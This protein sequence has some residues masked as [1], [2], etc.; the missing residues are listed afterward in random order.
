MPTA[1]L[2]FAAALL[3]TVGGS[4]PPAGWRTDRY[5]DPLPP[6]AVARLGSARLRHNG[7][8]EWAVLPGGAVVRTLGNDAVVRTWHLGDGRLLGVTTLEGEG[9]ERAN[10]LPVTL[11]PDGRWAAGADGKL[12][13]VWD[14]RTGARARLVPAPEMVKAVRFTPDGA[15]VLVVLPDGSV[16]LLDR[17]AG[18]ARRVLPPDTTR[19]E[20]ESDAYFTPDGTRVVAGGGKGNQVD[21]ADATT[22]R[23]QYRLRGAGVTAP[24]PDGARLAVCRCVPGGLAPVVRVVDTATGRELARFPVAEGFETV[25][26]DPGGATLALG[27]PAG[28]WVVDA[29][30]GRVRH[31]LTGPARGLRYAPGGRAL[32][33]AAG[34]RLRV[35][36]A[37]TGRERHPTPGGFPVPADAALPTGVS[38]GGR[39]LAAPDEGGEA[40]ALWGLADGRVVRR[41]PVDGSVRGLAVAAGGRAVVAVTADTRNRVGTWAAVGGRALAVVGLPGTGTGADPLV[42]ADGRWLVL[43]RRDG[44]G[45]PDPDPFRVTTWAAR[46]GAVATSR[47]VGP[48]SAARCVAVSADGG[49]AVCR[50]Q[51]A[52]DADPWWAVVAPGTGRV[53]TWLPA[54]ADAE[55][56]A[57]VSADGRLVAAYEATGDRPRVGVW[58]AATGR[59]VAVLPRGGYRRAGFAAGGQVLVTADEYCLRVWDLATVAERVR[60][61]YP[62]PP[63]VSGLAVDGAGRVAVTTLADGT[64]VVWDVS[65]AVPATARPADPGTLARWWADL[66]AGSAGL[67]YRAVWGLAGVPPGQVVPFLRARL[68][69]A[70]PDPAAVARLVAGLDAPGFADREAAQKSL[71]GM[72]WLVAPAVRRARPETASAEVRARLEAVLARVDPFPHIPGDIRVV[73]TIAVLEQ[74]GTRDARA[75]LDELARG[76]TGTGGAAEREAARAALARLAAQGEVDD[77]DR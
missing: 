40:V 19:T 4:F 61:Q 33:A 69:P 6:G 1:L 72:G 13:V 9:A 39:V 14:T 63:P 12:V 77:R 73:R 46:T 21:V 43:V 22:G 32:V 44:P 20:D 31:T 74:V 45:G 71:V 29:G 58:E 34:P 26:W 56:D 15:G 76:A 52:A 68:R 2:V 25:T 48:A 36:D 54:R 47:G 35:W 16:H 17:A 60:R 11:S 51:P 70:I 28:G 10:A 57:A 50:W 3:G 59:Q 67:G 64:G 49:T 18:T 7:L 75:L 41:L 55:V 53:T 23:P 65:P 5:G 24:S 37:A 42:T 62:G 30:A 66:G 27:G 38:P 8:T